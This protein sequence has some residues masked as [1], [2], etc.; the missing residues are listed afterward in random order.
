[1]PAIDHGRLEPPLLKARRR[2]GGTYQGGPEC[3]P[4]TAD[5]GEGQV[6]LQH[7]L[8]LKNEGVEYTT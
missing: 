2:V 7:G 4:Q 5:A 3:A 8:A 1:M 6:L